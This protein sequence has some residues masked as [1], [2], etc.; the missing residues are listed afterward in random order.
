LRAKPDLEAALCQVRGLIDPINTFFN[1]VLVM[2]EDEAVRQTRLGLLQR[3]VMLLK[4]MADLV[5][6]EGF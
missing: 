6:L 5:T 3:V 1:K 2:A 4:P